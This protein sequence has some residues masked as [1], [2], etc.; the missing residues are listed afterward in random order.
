MSD[1]VLD[2]IANAHPEQF[3]LTTAEGRCL[4]DAYLRGRLDEIPEYALR[5]TA[6]EMIKEWRWSI[7][8]A[9]DV[10]FRARFGITKRAVGFPIEVEFLGDPEEGPF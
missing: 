1:I 5:H 9:A 10:A 6:G 4:L 8:R 3:D 2:I 7:F